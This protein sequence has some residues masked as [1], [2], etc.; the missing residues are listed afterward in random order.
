MCDHPLNKRYGYTLAGSSIF[1]IVCMA[2]NGLLKGYREYEEQSRGQILSLTPAHKGVANKRAK[3]DYNKDVADAEAT[4]LGHSLQ[5]D[6]AGIAF[7]MVG[8]CEICG[9]HV[10]VGVEH[11]AG[12]AITLSCEEV[13]RARERADVEASIFNA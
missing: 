13:E 6:K 8:D 3:V 7:S 1:C 10:Y 5:W 11:R 4:K 9:A 2:C 12:H